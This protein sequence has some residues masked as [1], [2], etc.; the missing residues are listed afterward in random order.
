[1]AAAT[2]PPL[3]ELGVGGV[4]YRVDFELSD[5]GL[6]HFELDHRI[7]CRGMARD[8]PTGR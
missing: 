1:M 2:P 3:S 7:M 6:S 5:V 8:L 4:G